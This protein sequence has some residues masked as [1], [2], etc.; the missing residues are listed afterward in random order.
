MAAYYK[1]YVTP[2]IPWDVTVLSMLLVHPAQMIPK[3]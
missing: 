1:E 2:W 3:T